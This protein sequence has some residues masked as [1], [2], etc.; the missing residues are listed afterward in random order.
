MDPKWRNVI[1]I[2]I[3][4]VI[5][6]AGLGV[7]LTRPSNS[8]V[9]CGTP[10]A[11]K[12]PIVVDQAEI[13]DNVD[14]DVTFTTPG[15]AAVQQVYQGLVNYNGSSSTTFSGILAQSWSV[16][17]AGPY[18]SYVFHLRSGVHFS[19][20]DPY[21]AYVQ[22]YSLYRSLLVAQPPQFILEE[23]FYS[24]NFSASNPL[25]YYSNLTY[26][27][28]ANATLA[29]DL[30]TW[31]FFNPTSSEIALMETANQ[32]FQVINN[33]TIALNLGY[34]YLASNYTYLLAA[35][36][37][38]N[39]YAVDPAVVDAHGGVTVGGVNDWM[40]SNLLGTGPY[41]LE[42][43]SGV[44]GGGYSLVPDSKYWGAAAAA[45][46]PWNNGLQPA[47]SS[48]L[49][50]FQNSQPVTVNDLKTGQAA[51]A[52]FAY[53][54]P[55]EIAQIQGNPC[56]TAQPL[57][58][59]YSSTS[60][61]WWIYLN[62]NTYPFT[63]WSVRAAI[64]HAIDYAQ[65]ISEAFG[66]YGTQWVGPVPPG[67]PYYN[68]GGLSP[69][70]YN[71]TLAKQEIADSPCANNACAGITIPY[72]YIT[73]GSTWSETATLLEY[74]LSQIGIT[75]KPV[76]ISLDVL[77]EEQVT[78]T[79][80]TCTSLTTANG[81]PY[82]MG[83][84]FYTSDYIA[85]DDWTQ[86]DAYSLGSANAC[87]SSYANST[88]DSLV[89]SAA[90]SSDPATL[91]ADYSQMASL[92]YNNYS[93]IW[94]VVPTAFAVYSPYVSGIVQNP[95]ASAEPFALYFNTQYVT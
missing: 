58:T 16:S 15:W 56:I 10:L 71:L 42:D 63:N 23:N 14:P 35:I 48:I 43:Y 30:N 85:P 69:Y 36:S 70:A 3:V 65:I 25:S 95:M 37:A 11:S 66:G 84:E 49:V 51:E 28:A 81:G 29:N 87:M 50:I 73:P 12:N 38:P 8:K 45:A 59:V 94:L 80:G 52:S 33:L 2:V 92:M 6:V 78:D 26:D 17:T 64:A 86:N 41:L 24:T 13:P 88:M 90:A 68:P 31:N 67:Y 4:V 21:N 18:N 32:S 7:Y 34:G 27:Q 53:L 79:S 40:S 89:F 20:G 46:E 55:S 60:G 54:G 44:I 22:W 82:P 57:D 93:D 61:G 39:S 9:T 74:D 83:Q 5:V 91:T 19:N 76:G 47:K 75:I 1:V 77:L 62:Q 72:A